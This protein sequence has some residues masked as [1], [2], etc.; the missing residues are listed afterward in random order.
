MTDYIPEGDFLPESDKQDV[1]ESI[2]R[3]LGAFSF[4]KVMWPALIH[5]L[6]TETLPIAAE[7]WYWE[8]Q[9]EEFLEIG[10]SN[11]DAF[12]IDSDL[13]DRV[14][15]VSRPVCEELYRRGVFTYVVPDESEIEMLMY[16]H[17]EVYRDITTWSFMGFYTV[18]HAAIPTTS[19][20]EEAH[21]NMNV[22][23]EED[24]RIKAEK[25]RIRIVI[26]QHPTHTMDY[27][28]LIGYLNILP[29]DEEDL[30]AWTRA[31]LGYFGIGTL[32]DR[33]ECE[34]SDFII[35]HL[36][37]I[38]YL[39]PVPS[40]HEVKNLLCERYGRDYWLNDIGDGLPCWG[41]YRRDQSARPD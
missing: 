18:N 33:E 4:G 28:P 26:D 30:L 31:I 10:A 41:W 22:N 39:I 21:A 34:W 11:T 27:T 20:D 15:A 12:E 17:G 8:T 13:H 40:T 9:V 32:L 35:V 24:I 23:M 36:V 25:E 3:H 37:M 1:I 6:L 16:C 38:G 14:K 2:N 29:Y 7:G 19:I 5:Y